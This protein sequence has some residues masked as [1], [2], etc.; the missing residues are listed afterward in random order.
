MIDKTLKI[1]LNEEVRAIKTILCVINRISDVR[2]ISPDLADTQDSLRD[3]ALSLLSAA[4]STYDQYVEQVAEFSP[5]SIVFMS[6][7]KYISPY[8][9]EQVTNGHKNRHTHR[10]G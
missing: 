5:G 6:F 2:N 9:I 1:D 3:A 8:I 4:E 10:A 7:S